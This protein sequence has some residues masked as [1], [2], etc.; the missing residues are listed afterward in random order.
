MDEEWR[1]ELKRIVISINEFLMI[2]INISGILSKLLIMIMIVKL[3]LFIVELVMF[4]F[5]W[6]NNSFV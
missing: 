1:G 2:E 6:L 5:W 3:W 4:V